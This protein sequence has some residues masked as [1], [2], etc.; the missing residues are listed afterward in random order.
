[1][2]NRQRLTPPPPLELG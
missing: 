1:M 2:N